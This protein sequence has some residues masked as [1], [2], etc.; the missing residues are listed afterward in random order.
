MKPYELHY[1]CTLNGSCSEVCQFHTDTRN[2][3]LIT[4]PW[5]NIMIMSMDVPMREESQAE[6]QIKRFGIPT[7]WKIKISKLNCPEMVSDKMVQGP[8][9]TF[10]HQRSFKPITNTTTQMEETITFSL[11]FSIIGKWFF[12]LVKREIDKVFAHRHEATKRYFDE[13]YR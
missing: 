4:P 12:P 8:F 1:N 9:N 2:L 13:K 5:M 7:Y 10:H 6:F 3:P 11:P